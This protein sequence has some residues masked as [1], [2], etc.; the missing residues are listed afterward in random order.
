MVASNREGQIEF[1]RIRAEKLGAGDIL[2]CIR[3]HLVRDIHHGHGMPA[4]GEDLGQVPRSAAEVE[5]VSAF[6]QGGQ[7]DMLQNRERA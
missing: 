7:Q 5:N 3:P 1:P 4:L 2:P 6:G